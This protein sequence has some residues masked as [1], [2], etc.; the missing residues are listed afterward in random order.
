MIRAL[1]FAALLI[2]T[3][4][5]VTWIDNQEITPTQVRQHP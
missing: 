2:V 4:C 5:A 3:L 1:S